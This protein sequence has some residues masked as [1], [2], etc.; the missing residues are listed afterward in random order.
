VAWEEERWADATAH[1]ER[2]VEAAAKA[3]A[4]R[5][6]RLRLA[7]ARLGGGDLEHA[8]AIAAGLR[9]EKEGLTD[10]LAPFLLGFEGRLLAAGGDLDRARVAL[11]DTRDE[12]RRNRWQVSAAEASLELGLV[13]VG[14]GDLATAAR[15][16]TEA[17]P[18]SARPSTQRRHQRLSAAAG[19]K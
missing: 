17:T 4:R 14:A 1:F 8:H 2:A 19:K 10:V 12:Y 11:R 16:L 5:V 3:S 15:H 7:E 9:A 6:A 18:L 13:E